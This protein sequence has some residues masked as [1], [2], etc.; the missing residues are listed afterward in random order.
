VVHVFACE[1][2]LCNQA[3]FG[4]DLPILYEDLGLLLLHRNLE[5]ARHY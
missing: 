1:R 3:N 5:V 2:V 4:A